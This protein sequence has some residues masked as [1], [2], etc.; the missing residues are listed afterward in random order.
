MREVALLLAGMQSAGV[1]SSYAVFGAIAQMRYTQAVATMDVDVLV[2]VATGPALDALQPIYRYCASRGYALEGAAV[3]VGDWPVQFIPTFS[4]LTE[5]AVREAEQCEIQ[6]APIRVVRADHL[7]AIALAAGRPKDY[8][9]ILA[10]LE[11]GAVTA[12]RLEEFAAR[13]GLSAEWQRFRSRF[14]E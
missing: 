1:I 6:G 12:D 13:H 4:A 9:R 11:S 10:L 2:A 8:A 3:R 14:L 5:E 7:A